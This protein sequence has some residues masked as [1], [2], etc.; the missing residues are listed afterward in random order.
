MATPRTA[1][2]TLNYVFKMS[3]DAGGAAPVNRRYSYDGELALPQVF[4]GL[5]HRASQ[6]FG[7][8][9]ESVI[10]CVR[11]ALG[12]PEVRLDSYQDF[13]RHVFLPLQRRPKKDIKI[14]E[15][16]R[17]VLAFVVLTKE[18]ILRRLDE[19][20]AKARAAASEFAA[21]EK[22]KKEKEQAAAVRAKAEAAAKKRATQE[23]QAKI[24]QAQAEVRA[25][26]A[27]A[28]EQPATKTARAAVPSCSSAKNGAASEGARTE[29]APHTGTAKQP[30]A[31]ARAASSSSEVAKAEKPAPLDKATAWAGVHGVLDTFVQNL[32]AH[33]ADTFGDSAVPLDFKRLCEPVTAP[34]QAKA[35]VSAAPSVEAE[36]EQAKSKTDDAKKAEAVRHDGVFCDGCRGDMI[37][38][39]YK[40]RDCSNYDLCGPCIDQRDTYHTSLHR[41]VEIARP[42]ATARLTDR[43]SKPAGP[44][45][46]VEPT[47]L[48]RHAATC[49]LCHNGIFGVRFKC[50]VC[51]DYDVDAECFMTNV[52]KR[53]P[54][55]DFVRINVPG[56]HV[57]QAS[58]TPAARHS[59][60][61]CDGCNRSPIVGTRY[62]CMHPDCPDYDL[63]AVCE[64]L[65]IPVHPRDHP[66]LKLR[67]PVS[68]WTGRAPIDTARERV[69]AM[70]ARAESEPQPSRAA[71]GVQAGSSVAKVLEAF[72]VQCSGDAASVVSNIQVVEDESGDMTL[73][74]D[75]AIGAPARADEPEQAVEKASAPE[76]EKETP[77]VEEEA[78]EA[79]KETAEAEEASPEHDPTL[80]G[81]SAEES[82]P[83]ETGFDRRESEVAEV[84][85]EEEP[86]P[87]DSMIEEPL[88]EEVAKEEPIPD[89]DATMTMAAEETPK[90][91]SP[92][93]AAPAAPTVLPRATFVSDITLLDGISVPAGAE[94][95]KVWA[96]RA[97]PTGWPAGC[98]LVHVGGFSSTRF[99]G[100]SGKPSSFDVAA[101]EPDEVV[102]VAC[103]CKA[104]EDNGRYMDFWRLSLPDGTLF[105]ERLWIDLT[106]ES[107][108]IGTSSANL[109]SSSLATSFMAPSLDAQGKAA[110][111]AP[112][113]PQTAPS[114]P[115]APSSTAFSA[116]STHGEMSEFESVGVAVHEGGQSGASTPMSRSDSS[117][118]SDA[119]DGFVFLSGDEEDDL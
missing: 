40:C 82:V 26:Q 103:E 90:E 80:V 11:D 4:D 110:S 2:E 87:Q 78:P 61:R 36:S 42:G 51:P 33:L 94:F 91:T 30:A 62:R 89:E 73:V 8:R 46:T 118:A 1:G 63:C 7:L 119:T 55:H 111:I 74:A 92:D 16:R 27:S 71:A 75:V 117:A 65:P 99:A 21:A 9:P 58:Y 15:K 14:D 12:N 83:S 50:L 97:G 86:A 68:P 85:K 52:E 31:A 3:Y 64:A 35:T 22:R 102:S 105:G 56:D 13:L 112:S 57:K 49:D 34:A 44:S 81:A 38:N 72:G 98:R 28:R 41:F 32:N 106:I 17:I 114:H 116:P 6:A 18:Q 79:E 48:M 77:K 5:R 70:V 76:A 19:I 93:V 84:P 113:A 43:G 29:S 104:P 100:Q 108:D 107:E 25:K 60:F 109:S 69:R 20:E 24:A 59:G 23:K 88:S 115:S 39:R 53:H 95:Q 45:P 37:G 10:I 101:A 96:V 67:Q 47:P 66:F 54:G